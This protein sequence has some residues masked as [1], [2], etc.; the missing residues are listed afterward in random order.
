MT[1]RTNRAE[2]SWKAFGRHGPNGIDGATRCRQ[3]RVPRS[4]RDDSIRI[5]P[6]DLTGALR[7][8]DGSSDRID[9]GRRVH[10]GKEV[11]RQ[12]GPLDG[13]DE[14]MQ[15]R[16]RSGHPLN[17][18]PESTLVLRV[19]PSSIVATACFVMEQS[20]RR[21]F[22]IP[23]QGGSTAGPGTFDRPRG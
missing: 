9:L 17:D 2:G 12:R 4:G 14:S 11:L 6:D 15:I 21:Q 19:T 20:D 1:G 13:L 18:G 8:I 22:F 5:D 16:E 10:E 23:V 3:S 7:S